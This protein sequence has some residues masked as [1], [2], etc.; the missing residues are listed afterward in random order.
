M[1][2]SD[3]GLDLICRWR[4][5]G[6]NTIVFD[7]EDFYGLVNVPF[8]HPLAPQG[9]HVP[10]RNLPK[11]NRYV[12]SLGLHAIIRI[13]VF[14]D[15]TLVTCHSELAVQSRRTGH[16]WKENGEPGWTDPSQPKVQDY[17]LAMARM[18]ANS[19]ADEIQFDYVRFPAEGDQK[20]AR[21]PMRLRTRIGHRPT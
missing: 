17:N 18:A 10:I 12:H 13:A 5:A 21:L 9:K 11:A 19:G 8:V 14:R 16:A 7:V 20:D 3:K 2:G 6:G 15:E 1:A 4:E